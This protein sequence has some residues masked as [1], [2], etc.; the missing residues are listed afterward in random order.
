MSDLFGQEKMLA[1]SWKQ[2]FG[3]AMLIGKVET[4]VWA[5]KYRG[6]VLV[7]LSKA[8]YSEASAR[9][10]CGDDLFVKMCQKLFS[11]QSS[12]DLYGMAIATGRLVNC[13]E[14]RPEDEAAAFVQYRAPWT[15]ERT[16]KDGIVR[17][18]NQ[19]L[20]CHFYEDVRPIVPFPW[21]GC[22]GWSEVPESLIQ[23][24]KYI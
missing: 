9:S 21:K 23:T 16:G 2:P 7:C 6:P 22:Q 8:G 24:I 12:L 19:R 5:T 4:R 20:Y 13:R 14:M 3:S 18:V 15:E 10:I 17:K 1:L 11:V